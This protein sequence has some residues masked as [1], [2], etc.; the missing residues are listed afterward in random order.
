MRKASYK[1]RLTFASFAIASILSIGC[2]SKLARMSSGQVGCPASAIKIGDKSGGPFASTWTAT[3]RGRVFY[4]SESLNGNTSQYQCSPGGSV[5]DESNAAATTTASTV[6]T[7]TASA[8]EGSTAET[9]ESPAPSEPA[10]G[11]KKGFPK[12]ALGFSFASPPEVAEQACTSQ[13]H[14]WQGDEERS[15]CSGAGVDTGVPT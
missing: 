8:S 7:S 14:E 4:C 9:T 12:K 1:P 11:E 5:E 13:G 2:G 15:T 6:T 10:A 3:C